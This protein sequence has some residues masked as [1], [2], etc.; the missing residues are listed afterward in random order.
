MSRGGRAVVTASPSPHET[1][2]GPDSEVFRYCA[3]VYLAIKPHNATR[4]LV[5]NERPDPKMHPV[6]ASLPSTW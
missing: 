4:I 3:S 1:R 2:L 5:G 6:P